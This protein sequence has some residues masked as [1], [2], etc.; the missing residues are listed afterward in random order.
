MRPGARD[1]VTDNGIKM[2]DDDNKTNL[3]NGDDCGDNESQVDGYQDD[4]VDDDDDIRQ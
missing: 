1:V 4:C 3:D 2:E